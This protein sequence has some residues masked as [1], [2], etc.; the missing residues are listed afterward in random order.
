MLAKLGT[1]VCLDL[2]E[3]QRLKARTWPAVNPRLVPDYFASQR[4]RESSNWLTKVSLE[5]LDDRGREVKLF[6]AC[7]NVLLGQLV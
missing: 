2:L 1:E 7:K 5:E 6:G 3:V 4:L